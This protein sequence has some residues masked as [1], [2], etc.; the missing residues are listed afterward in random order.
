ME[1]SRDNILKFGALIILIGFAAFAIPRAT[2]IN[3]WLH[4]FT[5]EPTSITQALAEDTGMNAQG[6][7]YF[8][9]YEPKFIEE[10]KIKTVC[11]FNEKVLGCTTKDGIFIAEFANFEQ[12]SR[13]IVT[14]AHEMLHVAYDRLTPEERQEVNSLL[15]LEIERSPRIIKATIN[16]YSDQL[17]RLDEAHSIIGS[18]VENISSILENYYKNYFS[19]RSKSTKAY[20]DSPEG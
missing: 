5:Y 4:S 1:V 18:E 17:V 3:D 6:K 7:K 9:R 11:K 13:T 15:E 19:D 2:E 10:A 12:Y 8:Y 20:Q 16:G 14:A